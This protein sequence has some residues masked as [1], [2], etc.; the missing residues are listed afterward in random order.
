MC[1]VCPCES[2]TNAFSTE[3]S[4]DEIALVF[5]TVGAMLCLKGSTLLVVGS[6]EQMGMEE[7]N[8]KETFVP[9]PFI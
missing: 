3:A 5:P 6:Q 2:S 8:K 7:K 4:L 1:P 9:L